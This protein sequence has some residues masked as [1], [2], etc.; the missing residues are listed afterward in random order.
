MTIDD[1]PRGRTAL[2]V[3]DEFFSH[4]TDMASY[5]IR[6]N[7]LNSYTGK[8]NSL[9]ERIVGFMHTF[10]GIVAGNAGGFDAS[11][12]MI[13]TATSKTKAFGGENF[14]PSKA[15]GIENAVDINDG[16]LQYRAFF[17]R[18]PAFDFDKSTPSREWTADEIASILYKEIASTATYTVDKNITG[19]FEN[20]YEAMAFFARSVLTLFEE[21]SKNFPAT[22]ELYAVSNIEDQE[23][24]KEEEM[25]WMPLRSPLALPGRSLTQA[26]D[27]WW[28]KTCPENKI[29]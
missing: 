25:N 9:K 26:W 4:L 5:W 8:H 2:E 29:F 20:D 12:D 16:G 14:F 10:G 24:F 21:G 27:E 28:G 17:D 13:V 23:Y 15:K 7:N 3:Q 18:A 11:V 1:V 6:N 22:V 19:H